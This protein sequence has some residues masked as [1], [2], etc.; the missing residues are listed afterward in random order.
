MKNIPT[1]W[2]IIAHRDLPDHQT[3]KHDLIAV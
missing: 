2:G 3:V 1:I